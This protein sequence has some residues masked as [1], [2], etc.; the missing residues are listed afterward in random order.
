MSTQINVI[1]DNGGLSEK[2]RRQT[3]AN[4]WA[5][6]E[7]DARAKAEREGLDQRA[8]NRT[9]QGLDDQGRPESG[10]STGTQFRPDEPAASRFGKFPFALAWENTTATT[11]NLI[12]GDGTASTSF[13]RPSNAPINTAFSGSYT[14]ASTTLDWTFVDNTFP[15]AT[16][17]PY[18]QD[19]WL[20]ERTLLDVDIVK[21]FTQPYEDYRD[22]CLPCDG[23]AMLHVSVLA[24]KTFQQEYKLRAQLGVGESPNFG[25]VVRE[26]V[27]GNAGDDPVALFASTSSIKRIRIYLDDRPLDLLDSTEQIVDRS[28]RKTHVIGKSTVR[29]VSFPTALRQRYRRLWGEPPENPTSYTY[30]F[31]AFLATPVEPLING[32]TYYEASIQCQTTQSPSGMAYRDYSGLFDGREEAAQADAWD[33]TP[34]SNFGIGRIDSDYATF[35][36]FKSITAMPFAYRLL[37]GSNVLTQAD[38]DG[39]SAESLAGSLAALSPLPPKFLWINAGL[40]NPYFSAGPLVFNTYRSDI[41]N[42]RSDGTWKNFK[43]TPNGIYPNGLPVLPG[44]PAALRFSMSATRYTPPAEYPNVTLLFTTPYGDSAYCRTKLLELGFSPADLV[45]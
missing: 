25:F 29:E 6:A 27:E 34:I 19:F 1:V 16:L 15:G 13:S 41:T 22:F 44:S 45:P 36:N 32:V 10:T 14:F 3:Q 24:K 18:P 12:S 33:L 2:A 31:S 30:S 28:V 38:F 8:A 4:R 35:L 39:G 26:E 5:K 21:I 23:K 37:D 40:D 43:Q 7:A 9:E 42:A 20:R 11:V 17:T